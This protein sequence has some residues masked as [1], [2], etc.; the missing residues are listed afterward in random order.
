[1]TNTDSILLLIAIILL[2]KDCSGANYT[3]ELREI[4][5]E[6]SNIK[7]EIAKIGGK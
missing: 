1:M 3:R 5:N 2:L 7:R 6:L 4:R